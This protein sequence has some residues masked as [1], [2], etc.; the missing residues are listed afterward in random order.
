M[1][2]EEKE[3]KVIFFEIPHNFTAWDYLMILYGSSMVIFCIYA[4]YKPIEAPKWAFI[5]L[6]LLHVYVALIPLLEH[7][8]AVYTAI[9]DYKSRIV[10]FEKKSISE[11]SVKEYEFSNIYGFRVEQDFD[12][13]TPEG[14]FLEMELKNGEK[15]SIVN[16]FSRDR[17]PLE[18]IAQTANKR[19]KNL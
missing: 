17:K 14:W 8:S 6:G 9:F 3:N 2:F 7:Y 12:P 1:P 5:G 18:D 16:S 11:T 19:L 15:I 4:I 10:I 13:E